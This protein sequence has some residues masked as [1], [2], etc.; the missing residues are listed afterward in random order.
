MRKL[1]CFILVVMLF[2][3]VLAVPAFAQKPGFSGKR[4]V[5][6]FTYYRCQACHRIITVKNTTVNTYQ[7]GTWVGST[8]TSTPP[9]CTW[10]GGQTWLVDGGFAVKH[11]INSVEVD[12]DGNVTW[13]P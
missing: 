9:T 3:S 10:C 13:W 2:V 1:I 7:S 12:E 6:E 4:T 5:V 11:A 8:T